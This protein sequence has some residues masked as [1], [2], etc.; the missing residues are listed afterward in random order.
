MLSSVSSE[1]LEK[2]SHERKQRLCICKY[3]HDGFTFFWYLFASFY[4]EFCPLISNHCTFYFFNS[5]YTSFTAWRTPWNTT[6]RFLSSASPR[7]RNRPSGS[8][9]GPKSFRSSCRSQGCKR[10]KMPKSN[11][12][13]EDSWQQLQTVIRYIWFYYAHLYFDPFYD[14][15]FMTRMKYCAD[16][17]KGNLGQVCWKFKSTINTQ[18]AH[19]SIIYC[20]NN[21]TY[22]L[23]YYVFYPEL[24]AF[25]TC[26]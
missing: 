13:Q 15:A 2:R 4:C 16:V 9:P 25:T 22:N 10:E 21:F 17:A 26:F 5:N 6:D 19:I 3:R 14:F 24:V 20:F 18:S 23:K 7:P 11:A 8:I 1:D 12:D